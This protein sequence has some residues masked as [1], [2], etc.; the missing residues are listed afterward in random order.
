MELT[1]FKGVQWIKAGIP[2]GKEVI[3]YGRPKMFKGRYSIPHP[4]IGLASERKASDSNLKPV[5]HSGEKLSNK[6]LNS[7]G[8]EKFGHFY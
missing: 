2:I 5:Y 7:N 8:F 3:V 4:E 6:G 1:W